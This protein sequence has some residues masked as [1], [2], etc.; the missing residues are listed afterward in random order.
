MPRPINAGIAGT[1]RALK[2]LLLLKVLTGLGLGMKNCLFSNLDGCFLI[3][4]FWLLKIVFLNLFNELARADLAG[5]FLKFDL[6]NCI[7]GVLGK[8]ALVSENNKLINKMLSG[9]T[10]LN[11]KCCI[12]NVKTCH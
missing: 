6:L 10:I 3:D 2:R 11:N 7:G 4:D 5:F 12:L 1:R 9:S 8:S